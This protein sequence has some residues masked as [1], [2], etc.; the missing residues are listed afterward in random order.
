MCRPLIVLLGLLGAVFPPAQQGLK[1]HISVDLE[2]IA[3]VVDASHTSS[4]GRNYAA[5]REQM[6]AETNAAIAAAFD[7]GAAEVVVVDS[8][9]DKTNLQPAKL[10]RRATL[11]SGGPRPLGMVAGIDDT[12]D[13]AIF[14]GYH[15]RA[16][17][18]DATLDHTYTGQIKGVWFNGTE[19]GEAGLNAAAAGYFGVP[20]IF[21]SGDQSAVDELA[22]LIP[23]VEGV[24]VKEAIGRTAAHM[25]HPD[26]AVER[27][28]AGVAEALADFGDVAPLTFDSPVTLRIEV[29]DAGQADQVMFVPGMQR[30]DARVVEYEAPDAVSAYRVSRL[31]RL[32]AQ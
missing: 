24:A 15:A 32:L 28:A 1:V 25:I 3:G 18:T 4:S 22:A 14:I 2:G 6:I 17:T 30:V 21:V 13:A 11:I 16:S 10:D 23:G 31:V 26:E 7:A 5:A 9:G 8:H 27:I 29:S 20:V 12:F 19:L